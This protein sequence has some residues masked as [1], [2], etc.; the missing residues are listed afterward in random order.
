[1][2]PFLILHGYEGS[3]PGHWQHWLATRLGAAGEEVSF[4]ELPDPDAPDLPA[5]R[6]A[7][8]A[9]LAALPVPPVVVCH[10]LACLLWLHHADAGGRAVE[11]V[12]LA[13]P[14]SEAGAPEV[15]AAFFPAWAERD[16]LDAA[17]PAGT[18]LVCADD[19]PFCPEGA[20]A[21]YGRPLG[22]PTDLIAG[23][24]HLNPDAGLG[25]WPAIEA[26]CREGIAPITR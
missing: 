17:A 8:D 24:G 3:G 7:L 20:A 4:P 11:R 10:S 21:L 2:A 13:A 25:P 14:P 19:D 16:A 1:M 9:E 15:L 26:W 18:R 12:L 6:D 22:L 23:G 5:W